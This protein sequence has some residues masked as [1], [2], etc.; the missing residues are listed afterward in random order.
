M[1]VVIPQVIAEDRASSAQIIDGSLNF[2]QNPIPCLEFTPG[3]D[4]N[5][6]TWTVS[7]W[8][9]VDPSLSGTY[10]PFFFATSDNYGWQY[11]GLHYSI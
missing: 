11:E 7:F 5:R 9:R 8:A 3:S 10:H 1:G 6:S 4:G 2:N